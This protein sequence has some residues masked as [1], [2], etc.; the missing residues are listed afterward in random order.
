MCCLNS[1]IYLEALA[2]HTDIAINVLEKTNVFAPEVFTSWLTGSSKKGRYL[3]RE[4]CFV[5]FSLF[6]FKVLYA[7]KNVNRGEDI[8]MW[9]PAHSCTQYSPFPASDSAESTAIS[10]EPFATAARSAGLREHLSILSHIPMY[11]P[12]WHT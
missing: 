5:L 4:L 2:E 11:K 8:K 1:L 3:D 9:L 7:I 6:F 12:L 10:S